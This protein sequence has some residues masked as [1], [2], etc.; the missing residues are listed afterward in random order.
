MPG[1]FHQFDGTAASDQQEEYI[2]TEEEL[3]I[4]Y[5]P[6]GAALER[7][8]TDLQENCKYPPD[9]DDALPVTVEKLTPL[10]HRCRSCNGKLTEHLTSVHGAIYDMDCIQKGE[11]DSLSVINI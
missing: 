8:L 9:L 7:M 11:S 6:V 1:L 2:S 10:I 5:P 4:K 3:A